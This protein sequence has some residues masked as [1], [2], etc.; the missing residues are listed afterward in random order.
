V[1]SGRSDSTDKVEA[2]DAGADDYVTKP[3]GMDELM[4]RMRAVL[5]RHASEDGA[6]VVRFGNVLVDLASTRVTVG[7]AEVRL[8][9]TEWHL[10]QVLVRHPGKLLS[11]RRLLAEV[12]GPGYETAQGNLR[13]YVTQLRRKLEPDPARPRYIRTEPGMGYRFQP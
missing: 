7:D 8:T 2:L 10:L 11:H 12:W 6:P 4:A 3:F 9:P 13:L 1:L 5:R